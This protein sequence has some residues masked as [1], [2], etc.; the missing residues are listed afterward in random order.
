LRGHR[1]PVA[2]SSLAETF[3]ASLRTLY[4]DI[5]SLARGFLG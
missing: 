5:Q 1:R 3:G 2:A 4:R